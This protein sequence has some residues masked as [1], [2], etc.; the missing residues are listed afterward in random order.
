MS[1]SGWIGVD[2]DG[3]L[4]EYGG[5][6]GP[7]HIGAPVPAMLER[8]RAWVLEG[9]EVRVFTAR[10]CD[11][12]PKTVEVIEA[13]CERH[14]GVR[15]KVTNVKDF[16]M[17]ELWDD[18]AVQVE[19]NSG[20][21]AVLLTDE[22]RAVLELL[23]RRELA[24]VA[25]VE[26]LVS[27]LNEARPTEPVSLPPVPPSGAEPV[28]LSLADERAVLGAVLADNSVLA[29]PDVRELTHG[30]F[31][32][33]HARIWRAIVALDE[34]AQ[35]IDHLSLAEEL[36]DRGTLAWVGGP[37]Y[38]IGLEPKVWHPHTTVAEHAKALRRA[39]ERTP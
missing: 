33:N 8:V 23:E 19:K 36:K 5:W 28:D 11:N 27:Q 6:V 32:A 29:L 18:R 39:A 26:N 24:T 4:A 9:V 10:V 34:R 2:L 35:K 25:L 14:V 20:R 13:W 17:H 31:S 7:D 38:I 22:Q 16:G 21:R 30:H 37:P 1:T 12:D 15:L 3:T